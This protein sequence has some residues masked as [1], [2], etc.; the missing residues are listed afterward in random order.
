MSNISTKK[1][2]IFYYSYHTNSTKKLCEAINKDYPNIEI[3]SL[4]DGEAQADI[5]EYDY[6]GF[7]SGIYWFDFGSPV[8]EHLKKIKNLNGKPCFA[9][10]TSGSASDKYRF[11]LQKT[12]EEFG[13]KF[14]DGF[15]CQGFVNYFPLNIFGGKNKGKPDAAD[16]KNCEEFLQKIL[17]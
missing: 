14:L 12:I 15:A 1:I 9:L 2:A 6:I 13:G 11:Y 10:S 5:S 17:I 7:A 8:Y 3:F 16:I 4:T